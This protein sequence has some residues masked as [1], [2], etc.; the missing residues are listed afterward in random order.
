MTAR[1]SQ[2]LHQRPAAGGQ[3]R[4]IPHDRPVDGAPDDEGRAVSAFVVRPPFLCGQLVTVHLH[5]G[6]TMQGTVELYRIAGATTFLTLRCEDGGTLAAIAR[7]GRIGVA[8][9]VTA[10]LFPDMV[11]PGV[12]R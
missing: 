9:A 10:G 1:D 2:L 11:T 8:T 6:R 3:D 7:D 5:D 12:T 4:A